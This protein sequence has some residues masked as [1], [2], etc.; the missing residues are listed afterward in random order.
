M[1]GIEMTIFLMMASAVVGAMCIANC[2]KGIKDNAMGVAL[3]GA[4]LAGCNFGFFTLA[5]LRLA[6]EK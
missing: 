2:A 1:K 4:A 5:V 6:T 3:I